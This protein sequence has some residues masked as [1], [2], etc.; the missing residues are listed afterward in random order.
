MSSP[1][2]M[3]TMNNGGVVEAVNI[4]LAKVADNI[5]DVNTPPDKPR[6]V[7]LKITFKPDESRT[8]IASKAVVTTNLQP[9]EPQTIPVVLDKL[10]GAP[11][12]FESFTDNRPDQYRFDGMSPA[13]LREAAARP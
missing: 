6:T 12:L 4:A 5:A 11:M 10:D 9:Q 1:L 7:T 3:R 8:L 13:E 2:D